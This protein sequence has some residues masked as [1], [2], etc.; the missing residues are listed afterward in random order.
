VYYAILDRERET[1]VVI[2][3]REIGYGVILENK[4]CRVATALK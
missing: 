3:E 4:T 2:E 1:G